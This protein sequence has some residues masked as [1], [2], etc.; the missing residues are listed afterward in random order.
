MAPGRRES[1]VRR[2]EHRLGGGPGSPL[3]TQTRHSFLFLIYRTG[4]GLTCHAGHD[5]TGTMRVWM[6]PHR[7]HGK[8]RQLSAYTEGRRAAGVFVRRGDSAKGLAHGARHCPQPGLHPGDRREAAPL[9]DSP[10]GLA[11]SSSRLAPRLSGPTSP[12]RNPG[13]SFTSCTRAVRCRLCWG[14][15]PAGEAT[16]NPHTLR[17]LSTHASGLVSTPSPA[18]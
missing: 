11:R 13:I 10:S 1:R 9:P 15:P 17:L 6:K 2:E 16:V 12:N 5:V 3:A 18:T 4:A 7:N 8:T 14:A